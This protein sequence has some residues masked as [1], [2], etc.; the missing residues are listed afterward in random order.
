MD[1]IEEEI[2]LSLK[3]NTMMLLDKLP[4]VD[5]FLGTLD[6]KTGSMIISALCV[7][8]PTIYG[9][10]IFMPV[11]Y[12]LLTIW[13]LLA[14]FFIAS[15]LLFVGLTNSDTTLISTWIWFTMLFVAAM[16]LL[17]ILL[18]VF[19]ISKDQKVKVFIVFLGILWYSLTIYF[20]L[21][22]NSHRMILTEAA[23]ISKAGESVSADLLDSPKSS[24]QNATDTQEKSPDPP[25]TDENKEDEKKDDEKKDDEKKGDENKDDEKKDD[26]KKDDEPNQEDDGKNTR[27]RRLKA[28]RKASRINNRRI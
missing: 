25:N 10:T 23:L 21:V 4:E 20:I 24:D 22:V 11:S 18:A 9:C 1:I 28:L 2:M 19:F 17:M 26:E 7:L 12:L 15:I 16:Y 14:L 5:S 6:L 3:N 27:R 8:H 13:F